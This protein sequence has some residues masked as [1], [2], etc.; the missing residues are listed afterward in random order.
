[1][2]NFISEIFNRI[3]GKRKTY[4]CIAYVD[5]KK[6]KDKIV[7]AF[8]VKEFSMNR[9]FK[10]AHKVLKLKYPDKGLDLRIFNTKNK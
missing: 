8:E 4:K 5:D 7:D 9:A 2:E 6:G 1:M 10:T 3:I